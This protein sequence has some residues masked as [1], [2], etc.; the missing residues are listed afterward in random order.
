MGGVPHHVNGCARRIAAY[1]ANV[2]RAFRPPAYAW[3][4]FS[5][6]RLLWR[7]SRKR[8]AT[9]PHETAPRYRL[10]DT[11]SDVMALLKLDYQRDEHVRMI[12]GKVVEEITFLG[13]TDAQFQDLGARNAPRG[14]RWWWTTLTGEDVAKAD[15]PEPS[16]RQLQLG[17]DEVHEGL[18]G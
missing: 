5:R 3:D 9:G 11:K 12:V 17:L 1:P 6:Q 10:A 18:G 7:E 2:D 8:L 16:H 14:M 4:W 15:R 13:R